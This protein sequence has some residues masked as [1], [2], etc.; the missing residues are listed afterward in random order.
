MVKLT[1][2]EAL[3]KIRQGCTTLDLSGACSGAPPHP[4]G[5][6]AR[7]HACR[8]WG[9]RRAAPNALPYLLAPRPPRV[10]PACRR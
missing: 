3:E 4:R 10:R 6:A 7:A 1:L 9:V 5:T 8:G 2:D